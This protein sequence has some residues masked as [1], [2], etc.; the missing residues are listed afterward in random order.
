[1]KKIN[2][3]LVVICCKVSCPLFLFSLCL[4]P[5]STV[6]CPCDRKSLCEMSTAEWQ[7]TAEC[8]TKRLVR[9]LG[10]IERIVLP[11]ANPLFE[12]PR[13]LSTFQQR[14]VRGEYY[15]DADIVTVRLAK[16]QQQQQQPQQQE[17]STSKSSSSSKGSSSSSKSS[18]SGRSQVQRDE[19]VAPFKSVMWEPFR[20]DLVEI[21]SQG[22]PD[23]CLQD[24][25][26]QDLN[27][28][29][30]LHEEEDTKLLTKE[31]S[32]DFKIRN[33]QP[34]VPGRWRKEPY[35]TRVYDPLTDYAIT[36]A[37][38]SEEAEQLRQ[39]RI[40]PLNGYIGQPNNYDDHDLTE[41]WMCSFRVWL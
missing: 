39:Q 37:V 18:S 38:P 41:E 35:A 10:R 14:I 28:E 23:Y 29:Q 8:L 2:K 15:R 22:D 4:L 36:T 7:P 31:Y 27:T 26:L 5:L 33:G 25:A 11:L 34:S 13:Q 21:L 32:Y 12:I 9:L 30:H 6:Q 40:T 17:S 1:M 16:L 19:K 20:K 24:K 3:D